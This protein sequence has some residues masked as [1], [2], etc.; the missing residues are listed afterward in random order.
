[1]FQIVFG[2]FVPKE[3]GIL[4]LKLKPILAPYQSIF[5]LIKVKKKDTMNIK[6]L[7][8]LISIIRYLIIEGLDGGGGL[9]FTIH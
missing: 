9:V 1:M 7:I 6:T 8:C 2:D 3:E 4:C 5:T